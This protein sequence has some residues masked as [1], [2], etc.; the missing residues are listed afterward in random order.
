MDYWYLHSDSALVR[1]VGPVLTRGGKPRG[2]DEI[3]E[4][5]ALVPAAVNELH[6][7]AFRVVVARR[8]ARVERWLFGKADMIGDVLG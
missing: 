8:Q 4:L 7:L 6:E 3:G 2:L 5:G 1:I